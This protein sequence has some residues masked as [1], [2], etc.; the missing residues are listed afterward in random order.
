MAFFSRS[1]HRLDT[2]S[3]HLLVWGGMRG[4]LALALALGLPKDPPMR[5][6]VVGVTFAVV[7]FSTVVQGMTM[8]PALRRFLPQAP[9]PKSS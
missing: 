3:Q 2:G 9:G 1:K 5:H 4:A 8:G 6:E 7:A